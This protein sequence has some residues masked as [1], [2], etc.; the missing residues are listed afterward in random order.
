MRKAAVYAAVL[1]VALVLQA[2]VFPSIRVF[3]ATP[4][5]VL[6]TAWLSGLYGGVDRGAAV[7]FAGGIIQDLYLAAP[8]LGVGALV[9]C[10]LGAVAGR[11]Q[12]SLLHPRPEIVPASA[13]LAVLGGGVAYRLAIVVFGQSPAWATLFPAAI[14][15]AVVAIPWAILIRRI[16]RALSER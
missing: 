16:E 4:E 2:G 13:F 3:G 9:F 11:L 7:G 15:S 14:Y 8:R 5:L 1:L 12:E 10:I 6:L